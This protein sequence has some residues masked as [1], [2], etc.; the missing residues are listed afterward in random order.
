MEEEDDSGG[1]GG[2][3]GGGGSDG[4]RAAPAATLSAR[5][6]RKAPKNPKKKR[7]SW[8]RRDLAKTVRVILRYPM[9]M[10][11]A[12]GKPVAVRAKSGGTAVK[13]G[14]SN[15]GFPVAPGNPLAQL[16][17]YLPAAEFEALM[18]SMLTRSRRS[19]S[20]KA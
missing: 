3:T 20:K 4:E 19:P 17:Q 14:S 7:F 10:G 6:K 18:A 8:R 1:G 13:A 5:R 16:S 2:S 15:L 11:R 12:A 9:V